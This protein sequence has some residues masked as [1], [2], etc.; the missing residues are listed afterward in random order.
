MEITR[1]QIAGGAAGLVVAAIGGG[2]LLSAFVRTDSF[3]YYKQPHASS[4]PVR[5]ALLASAAP[6]PAPPQPSPAP[7]VTR[8]G[9]SAVVREVPDDETETIVDDTDAP[10]DAAV[11]QQ[12]PEGSEAE[13]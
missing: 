10:P 8:A 13:E 1:K 2:L 12:D 4:Y 5:G 6:I 7:R 3:A 11:E 9:G